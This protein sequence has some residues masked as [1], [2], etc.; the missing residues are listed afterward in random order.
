MD[1]CNSEQN[2]TNII[3]VRGLIFVTTKTKGTITVR[4][5]PNLF[6]SPTGNIDT[7]GGWQSD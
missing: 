4:Y 1:N 2:N 7:S 6:D 5:I 3:P